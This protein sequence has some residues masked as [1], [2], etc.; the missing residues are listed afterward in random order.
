MIER[1][2]QAAAGAIRALIAVKPSGVNGLGAVDL[3]QVEHVSSAWAAP[4][5]S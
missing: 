4:P 2:E 3:N 5:P 1:R